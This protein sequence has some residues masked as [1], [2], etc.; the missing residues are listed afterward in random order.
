MCLRIP[1]LMPCGESASVA[2]HLRQF[3]SITLLVL[4]MQVLV[5]AL[6][7]N[8][9]ANVAAPQPIIRPITASLPPKNMMF[10]SR[11]PDEA[12]TSRIQSENLYLNHVRWGCHGGDLLRGT[13]S[14]VISNHHHLIFANP[15]LSS[16]IHTIVCLIHQLSERHPRISPGL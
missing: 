7:T 4:L 14:L 11:G 12:M 6:D 15:N 1:Q 9:T 2:H 3:H 16:L 13:F 8:F 5:H 10:R